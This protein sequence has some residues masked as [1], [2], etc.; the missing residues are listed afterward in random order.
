MALVVKT[1]SME[2]GLY[3]AG[4]QICFQINFRLVISKLAT[5]YKYSDFEYLTLSCK[6]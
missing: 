2:M 3:W 6:Y 1:I 5:F 4:F